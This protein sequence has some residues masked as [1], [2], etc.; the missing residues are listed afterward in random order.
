MHLDA[1]SVVIENPRFLV[2]ESRNR[3]FSA[4]ELAEH[5]A[6]RVLGRQHLEDDLNLGCRWL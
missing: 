2:Q 3:G 6:S 4:P 5:E 1:Q